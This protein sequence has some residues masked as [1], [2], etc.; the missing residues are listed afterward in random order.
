MWLING[1]SSSGRSAIHSA[2]RSF[3]RRLGR[4]R[5]RVFSR[6]VGIA[7]VYL[8]ATILARAG[9]VLLIPL[10]TRK[11]ALAAY[12]DYA[13]AQTLIALLSTPIALGMHQAVGRFYFDLKDL[14]ASKQRTG[15]AAR[16]LVV[17]TLTIAVLLEMVV[18]AT[19]PP[20]THGIFGR[21]ELSC[22]IWAAA[23]SSI[24]L[25][26]PQYLRCAQ[27]PF[28]AAAFQLMEF[29]STF[30]SGLLLVLVAGRGLRGA[31]EAAA[32]AGVFN[33]AVAIVFILVV[34]S[35][36]LSMSILREAVWFSLPSIPHAIGNQI[37]FVTDRWV[38]KFTGYD[39][40]LGSYSLASQL[41]TPV[42]MAV[43]AW[44]QASSPDFGETS[45]EGGLL[46]MAR[47][48]SSYLRSYVV[49]A[50]ATSSALCLALPIA[51]PLVGHSF[52]GALRIVPFLCAIIT[53]ES[54]YSASAV[55]AVY[56]NRPASVPKVTIPAGILNVALNI[57]LVPAM[58]GVPG[59][60]VARAM[61]MGFRSGAMWWLSRLHLRSGIDSQVID[62]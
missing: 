11:L 49:I 13:L 28:P 39:V 31:I 26:P 10:Y 52:R 2:P 38:M 20:G 46:A 17:V 5:E 62:A 14:N 56:A 54:L 44:H 16:W 57:V 6:R 53:I 60:L 9:S 33:G 8:G 27:R 40:A 30:G 4:L 32:L 23:G 24:G 61:S 1:K 19:R 55:I 59:A 36:P 48:S 37:Q 34:M 41:T 35:G 58:G 51:A 18:L 47:R 50:L 43:E 45:R 15:S 12:G 3:V 21:W 25:V 22:I 42:S 29:T 7:T